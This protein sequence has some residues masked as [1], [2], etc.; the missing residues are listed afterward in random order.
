MLTDKSRARFDPSLL[1]RSDCAASSRSITQ[2]AR[3]SSNKAV[4]LHRPG[5][6]YRKGRPATDTL[7]GTLIA[8]ADH[9]KAGSSQLVWM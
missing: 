7:T 2:C 1:P 8:S 9:R 5:G 6:Q 3:L 4:H